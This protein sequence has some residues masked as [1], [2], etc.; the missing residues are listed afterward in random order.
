MHTDANPTLLLASG[1]ANLISTIESALLDCGFQISI[2]GSAQ[3]ALH[4]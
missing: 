2:A 1:S 4:A 3:E